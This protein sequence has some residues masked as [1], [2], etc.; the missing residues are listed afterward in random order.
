MNG[1]TE[2][3]LIIDDQ[4]QSKSINI[5]MSLNAIETKSSLLESI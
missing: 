4:L 5:S 2:Y 1:C 3:D